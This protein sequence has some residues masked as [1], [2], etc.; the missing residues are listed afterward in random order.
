[1]RIIL[2][3]ETDEAPKRAIQTCLT[4]QEIDFAKEPEWVL[5]NAYKRSKTLLDWNIREA[6]E[7]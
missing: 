5:F 2:T 7:K 4:Q 3:V 1:M 6:T